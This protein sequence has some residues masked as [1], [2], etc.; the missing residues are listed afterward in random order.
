MGGDDDPIG[1]LMRSGI[2]SASAS[3][4]AS[5]STRGGFGAGAGAAGPSAPTRMNFSESSNNRPIVNNEAVNFPARPPAYQQIPITKMQS[6]SPINKNSN[7]SEL[8]N[9]LNE[10]NGINSSSKGIKKTK[11]GGGGIELSI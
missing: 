11:K 10:L 7:D 6:P 8:D 9:L 1:N 4:S 2:N 3:A 5:V